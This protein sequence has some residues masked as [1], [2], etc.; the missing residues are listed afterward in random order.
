MYQFYGIVSADNIVS[1]TEVDWNREKAIGNAITEKSEIAAFYDYSNSLTSF[2]ND[3]FQNIV[4]DSIPEDQQVKAHTDFANDLRMIRIETKNGLRFYI[5]VFPSYG[6]IY[7][8]GTLS[9]YRTDE[10]MSDWIA[11]NLNN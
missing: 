8:N 11:R 10:Q 9:Y 7:G 5:E 3:E 1:I 4:F 2:G 6:W